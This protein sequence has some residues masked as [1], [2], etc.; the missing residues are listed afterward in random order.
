MSILSDR[1]EIHL[2]DESA[3]A[4]L[5]SEV[6]SA[7]GGPPLVI[8]LSG[9]LGAGKTTLA[10][11]L[12]RGLG[13]AGKVVSPT[14]TLMEPYEVGG[15]LIFHIDL[16]RIADPAELEFLGLRDSLE[17]SILLIEW[18]A[19]GEGWLPRPDL[20][21]TLAPHGKGRTASIEAKSRRGAEVLAEI[22]AN[23]S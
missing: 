1:R 9:E 11:G 4:T 10:R 20:N 12:L 2:P 3:T 7:L 21:I 16:Y 5:G 23:A 8:F 14:Y 18:P 22:D 13:Y 15:R 19:R 6:A 17:D